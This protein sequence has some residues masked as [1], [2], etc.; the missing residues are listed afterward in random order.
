M[1]WS[2]TFEPLLDPLLLGV[3]AFA[4]LLLAAIGLWGRQRGIAFRAAA[5]AIAVAALAN[6]V[7]LQ[8]ERSGTPSVVAVLVDRTQSALNGER[9]TETDA[10]LETLRDRFARFPQFEL[11]EIDIRSADPR[12]PQTA[13]LPALETALADVPPSRVGGAIVITDGQVHDL[14]EGVSNDPFLSIPVH[15]LLTGRPDETDRRVRFVTAPRFAIVG[16]PVEFAYTIEDDGIDPGTPVTVS[17]RLDGDL[18]EETVTATGDTTFLT[19][20][21]ENAGR[22]IVELDVEPLDGEVTDV[23]NAAIALIDGVRENLRVLLISGEPH[24]GE[25]AWRNL[26]KSD[27]SVDMVHFTI[28]RPPEKQDGTPIN[29]LSLIAFPTRELFVERI[30]DFDLIIFDRYQHRN[31]LPILYYDYIAR[32]VEDGGALL[33]AAGPE[34]AGNTSIAQT[35]LFPALPALPTG[36]VTEVGFRPAITDEGQRHPVTRALDGSETTPPSWSRWFRQIGVTEP[37]GD[38]VMRGANDE[39]L[40]VLNRYGEGRVAMLLSDHAWLWAR[41][42]EGGGPHVSL[43]RRTAHWLMKEPELEEER[44]IAEGDG[45]RLP[46]LRQTM[47]TDARSVTVVTPSGEELEVSLIESAPGRY[48]G[49]V[50]TDEIGLY[51]V[52]DDT[53]STLAHVGPVNAPEWREVVATPEIMQVAADAGGGSVRW[54]AE[55]GRLELPSINPVRPGATA[56]GGNWIGLRTSSDTVLNA[57]D[58]YPLFAGLIGLALLIGSLGAAWWREGRS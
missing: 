14:S 25:R 44:L 53:L 27:A 7:L 37:E 8:E 56:S 38:V 39:P 16:K 54:L 24:A 9:A 34:F 57:V 35:P 2:V 6:P 17:V 46:I 4:L 49:V 12:Q 55:N 41:G 45:N 22:N 13:I 19:L 20:E 5:G 21:L 42:F 15:T 36:N 48:E 3:I 40:L 47:A 10:A 30:D 18:I 28:L 52:A 51:R 32:Y 23:N 11:R 26:L 1:N 50:E 43:Y 33:I 29:E 31:V 58:R